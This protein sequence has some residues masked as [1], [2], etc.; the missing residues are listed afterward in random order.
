MNVL[1]L[2]VISYLA[3]R[4]IET[5]TEHVPS[6][7]RQK[8]DDRFFTPEQHKK[9]LRMEYFDEEMARHGYKRG[10][11]DPP[12]RKRKMPLRRT[13]YR[14]R[15]PRTSRRS[16]YAR[17]RLTRARAPGP[18]TTLWPISQWTKMKAVYTTTNAGGALGSWD[19]SGINVLD[20][21]LTAS[22]QQ[23][24][25]SDQWGTLYQKVKVYATTVKFTLHNKGTTGI[26]CGITP[27]QETFSVTPTAWD[28][29]KEMPGTV[30]RL[31]SPDDDTCHLVKKM[32]TRRWLRISNLKDEK[33]VA[34]T[35]PA[36]APTRDYS[37]T[38]WFQNMDKTATA[39]AVEIMIE[40]TYVCY[41]YDRIFPARS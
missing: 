3:K 16:R 10:R 17:K 25:G 38:C 32:N 5:A 4:G 35:F 7:K 34:C 9:R 11:S 24:L 33:D 2:P 13:S 15:R 31:L 39:N 22:A 20:P 21:F 30:A 27:R 18:I 37:I 28:H 6:Y 8:L 40:I 19:V 26:M 41:L 12:G 14:R 29:Y 1:P 23:C 36:T